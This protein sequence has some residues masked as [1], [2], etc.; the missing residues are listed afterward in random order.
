MIMYR[1]G[2]PLHSAAMSNPQPGVIAALAEAGADPN[3]RDSDQ[4]TPLHRAAE[5][6][7]NPAVIVALLDIGADPKARDSADK[8]PWD[9]AKSNRFIE[10]SD[11]WQRLKAA[12]E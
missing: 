7:R 12:S 3:E 2:T 9:Y 10:G 8:T 5:S 1:L 4:R 6:N 11:A